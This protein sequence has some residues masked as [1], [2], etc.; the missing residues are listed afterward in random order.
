MNDQ[1][2][3]SRIKVLKSIQRALDHN[4]PLTNNYSN[5]KRLCP[6]N[7]DTRNTVSP[8]LIGLLDQEITKIGGLL[9][10]A[11]DEDHVG[12]YLIKLA[13]KVDAKTIIR[14]SSNLLNDLKLDG[15]FNKEGMQVI[16]DSLENGTAQHIKAAWYQQVKGASLGITSIDYILADTGTIVIKSRPNLS[17]SLSLLPSI[18]VAIGEEQQILPHL[19]DLFRQE[20]NLKSSSALTF[21]TGP[22]RTADI[23]Q[24]LTIGVHGPI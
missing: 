6:G 13:K 14:D 18:H 23:E 9:Y 17:R 1:T 7:N 15:L 2:D 21:I 16:I 20:V 22:S 10:V 5:S 4:H 11:R 8:N 3:K 19:E 24:T 12:Q